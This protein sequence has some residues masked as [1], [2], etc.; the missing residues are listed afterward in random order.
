MQK[1][2]GSV[3]LME[4]GSAARLLGA[5]QVHKLG[6]SAEHMEAPESAARLLSALSSQ[7]PEDYAFHMEAGDIVRPQIVPNMHKLEGSVS[8]MGV[9]SAAG[10][11]GARRADRPGVSAERIARFGVRSLKYVMRTVL[12]TVAAAAL[13]AA[14][15]QRPKPLTHPPPL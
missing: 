8:L 15:S 7:K 1:V 5:K 10:R 4:V 3:S 13:V 9:E 2:E 11:R 12:A 6:G 14:Y